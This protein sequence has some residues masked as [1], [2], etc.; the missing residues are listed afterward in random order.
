MIRYTS[1]KAEG[2]KW[3][4]VYDPDLM[5]HRRHQVE[6]LAFELILSSTPSYKT[7]HV[8]T[9]LCR[10]DSRET[11]T[12]FDH[13][14]FTMRKAAHFRVLGLLVIGISLLA[15][16]G[17]VAIED[18][19]AQ[20]QLQPD[21]GF[22][23]E[24]VLA[25]LPLSTAVAFAPGD[26]TF[27]AIKEGI[28]RVAQ[29]GT[30]LPTPFINITSIV[31]RRTD[32]GLG[33]LAVD[34]QFPT[35]PYVYLFFTYD[36]PERP[37]DET[38][39]RLSR[40]VR[41]QADPAQNYNVAKAGTMEVILGKNSV[42]GNMASQLASGATIIPE[43]ASC[44]T[45]LTMDGAPIEDCIPSDELSHTAGTLMFGPDGSLYVSHGDGAPYSGA[46]K[47]SLRTQLLE[48]LAGKVLRINP[49]TGAG[50]SGNPFYDPANP[51]SNRSKVWA[52]GM[53]NPFRLTLNP[54]NGQVFLGDVGSS[55]WEEVNSGKGANFGWPCYEGGT[56]E[57]DSVGSGNTVSLKSSAFGN[58]S[59]TKDFCSALYTQGL[60]AVTA[61]RFAYAHPLDASGK[62]LGASVTGVAFY[63]GSTYPT[64]YRGSLF[65]ADFARRTIR[66]LRFDQNGFPTVFPFATEVSTSAAGV[67]HLVTGPDTNI[68]ALYYDTVARRSQLRRFRYTGSNNTPPTVVLRAQPLSGS[69]PLSVAFDTSGT[70]DADGQSLGY[71]WDFGD[72]SG[73]TSSLPNPTHTYQSVGTFEATVVVREL[74]APFAESS[75]SVT[76]RTGVTPPKVTI[77]QPTLTTKYAIGDTVSFSGYAEYQGVRVPHSALTWSIIQQHNLH[78]HLVDEISGVASGSF[79]PGEHSDNTR[80]MV[81]LF[82]T[83]GEGLSDQ[84]CV[85]VQPRTVPVT[86]KS[87]PLGAP[88]SYIDE[89]IEVLAPY[90]A[91]PIVNSVQTISAAAIHQGRSFITWSDGL[92][93]RE[94]TFTVPSTPISFTAIYE[95]LPPQAK[96]SY[97]PSGGVA[98]LTLSFNGGGSTDPETPQL[99]YLWDFGNGD[100]STL[101]TPSPTFS[102]PGRYSVKLTVTDELGLEDQATVTITVGDPSAPNAAP[103]MLPPFPQTVV[104]GSPVS[105]RGTVSDDGLPS[106]VL[107]ILWS[108]IRG[109]GVISF[110]SPN[111]AS[112]GAKFTSAGTYLVKLEANDSLLRTGANTL[113]TLNPAGTTFGVTSLSLIDANTDT[114]IP[115]YENIVNGSTIGLVSPPTTALNIRA[116]IAGSGAQSV[117]F[118][119]DA[120]AS[121]TDNTTPFALQPSAGSDYPSWP[122]TKKRYLVTAV[123][124]SGLNGS[125]VQGAALSILFTLKDSAP[126]NRAP[127]STIQASPLTGNAPLTVNF[128]GFGSSDPDG[129]P[130]TYLWDFGNG[131]TAT[132]ATASRTFLRAG[133]YPVKLTVADPLNF[134]GEATTTVVVSAPPTTNKAPVV[135]TGL[136]QTVVFGSG[137]TLKGAASDDGLPSGILNLVWS[138][139]R[140]PGTITFSAPTAIT[141]GATFSQLGTYMF[142]LEGSDT[143]LTGSKNGIITLNPANTTFGVSS[144]AL[145][146]AATDLPFTG[147]EQVPNGATIVLKNL[148]S[149]PQIN[150]RANTSGSGIRSVRWLRD[151][152]GLSLDNTA[153]FALAPSSRSD[154][155]AWVTG[156]G[157]YRITAVPYSGSDGTGTQGAALSIQFSLK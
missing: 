133:S 130:L 109:P 81:C 52:Y 59:R 105:L 55:S 134:K 89:E 77:V 38:L 110:T 37:A 100:T 157:F 50:L 6:R 60:G 156:V 8:S 111:T 31:N 76:I 42:V 9:G 2:V 135:D 129:D 91:S 98:P 75:S 1:H 48:S 39:P 141:T 19:E 155:P 14:V 78:E 15:S 70:S 115:G 136:A 137:V 82:A 35:R 112:T 120:V 80:Y 36:P 54:S 83:L 126:V 34:P 140:G 154:Y 43:P 151:A 13:K 90:I 16:I 152:A 68:Y 107:N 18:L 116:N 104:F 41:V 153:P 143:Q 118:L 57:R 56:I 127:V 47:V 113:V 44:M 79:Q 145:I 23:E 5:M 124:H 88:I 53:R 74:T 21:S 131:D 87:E 144:F 12:I 51:N 103:S 122:Y 58:F 20:S 10:R 95:N 142:K 69:V 61:P 93:T 33:G 72:G 106:G 64:Q 45:G 66:Y 139:L 63:S 99:S 97:S 132:T 49:D 73:A 148:G 150:V 26:R 114:V 62:D 85:T 146:N 128:N 125:G 46:N 24:T 11:G 4:D 65:F 67:V 25:D 96:I 27:I 7:D 84:Q 92:G 117:V 123:P 30:L 94:R 29:N 22:V 108:R 86:F 32:R 149:S 28:V 17:G 147:Y 3:R 40:L 121:T 119:Q 138:R 71:S 102:T 101:V